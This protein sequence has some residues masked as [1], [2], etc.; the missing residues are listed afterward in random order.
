MTTTNLGTIQKVDLREAWHNEARDFTPWLAENI[1]ELG[2]AL[3]VELEVRETEA[4]VG[5]FSLDILASEVY[6][7]YDTGVKEQPAPGTSA[8]FAVAAFRPGRCRPGL[9]GCG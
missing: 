3:G 2:E 7:A 9:A 4:A 8:S 6:F 1:D 5:D